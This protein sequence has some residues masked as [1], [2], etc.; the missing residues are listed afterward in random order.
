ML[1][2]TESAWPAGQSRQIVLQVTSLRHEQRCNG[3]ALYPGRNE[4]AH[5]L[6]ERRRHDLEKGELD[7]DI[8][9]RTV[10]EDGTVAFN[11]VTAFRARSAMWSS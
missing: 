10:G 1:I 5:G 3:D 9:V 4:A 2:R 7:G 11:R 6:G 8:G